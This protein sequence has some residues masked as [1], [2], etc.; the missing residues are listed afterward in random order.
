MEKEARRKII[1]EKSEYVRKPQE[2]NLRDE[3]QFRWLMFKLKREPSF[4]YYY[5]RTRV[6]M[7]L[8]KYGYKVSYIANDCYQIETVK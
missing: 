4:H 7:M 6:R 3:I 1:S 5:I 2:W 8:V